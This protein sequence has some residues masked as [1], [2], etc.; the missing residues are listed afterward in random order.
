MILCN[1]LLV[2]TMMIQ[3]ILNYIFE[4]QKQKISLFLVTLSSIITL[5]TTI[6]IDLKLKKYS[7][8]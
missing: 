5:L 4:K 1:Y 2:F 7:K 8:M 6:T 3:T